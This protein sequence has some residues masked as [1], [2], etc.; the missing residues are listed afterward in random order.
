[1]R[2]L[3]YNKLFSGLSISLAVSFIIGKIILKSSIYF[4]FI[5]SFFGGIYLLLGWM[6]YLRL[7]GVGVF[8]GSSHK[9]FKKH[10]SIL[11]RFSYKN[12]GVY[13]EDD[14]DDIFKRAELP[15]KDSAKAEMYAYILCG[16]VLL[17]GAQLIS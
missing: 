9:Y 2:F 7:D 12:K 3:F 1:M 5:A 15:E 8:K 13:S 16:I 17:L 11:D 10:F 4:I 6:S 14:K